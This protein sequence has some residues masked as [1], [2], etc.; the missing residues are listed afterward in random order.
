MYQLNWA[1]LLKFSG[2]P[3]RGVPDGNYGLDVPDGNY[4]RLQ[5][6]TLLFLL[7]ICPSYMRFI[8]PTS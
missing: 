7:V 8:D 5:K 4:F 2:S 3:C 1:V 6:S